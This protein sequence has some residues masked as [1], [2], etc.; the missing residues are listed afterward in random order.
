MRVAIYGRGVTPAALGPLAGLPG[1]VL[2]DTQ[3]LLPAE[4]VGYDVVLALVGGDA[5]RRGVLPPPAPDAPT[6]TAAL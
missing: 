3:H 4:R 5:V 2:Y 6:P 1:V